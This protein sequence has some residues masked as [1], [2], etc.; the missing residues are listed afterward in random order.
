MGLTQLNE[1][2]HPQIEDFIHKKQHQGDHQNGDHDDDRGFLELSNAG[3]GNTLHLHAGFSQIRRK[4]REHFAYLPI[5]LT[6]Y[7]T[8]ELK[9]WQGQQGSNPRPSVL[10]TDA[11]PAE[12]YPCNISIK[13]AELMNNQQSGHLNSVN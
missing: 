12:L 8:H 6:G 1:L 7:Q 4:T 11:L 13:A 3:P 10:E 9:L 5:H 2:L